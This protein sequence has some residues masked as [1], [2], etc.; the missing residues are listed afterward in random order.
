MPHEQMM[1]SPLLPAWL[2]VLWAVLLFAVVVVHTAHANLMSGQR[3]WWHIGHTAMAAVM[4]LM[5][6]LPPMSNPGPYRAGLL[7]FAAG[8]IALGVGTVV[9]ARREGGVCLLWVAS[10]VEMLAMTYMLLPMQ[11]RPGAV[12]Y[13]FAL[14]LAG[15]ALAWALGLWQREP[16]RRER[17]AVAA[18]AAQQGQGGAPAA[19]AEPEP[20]R[21]RLT[22]PGSRDV[23]VT[24]AVMSAS[25]AYMVVFM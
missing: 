13:V 6:L 9:L 16:A 14:Y 23:P 21:P 11:V 10:T 7:L 18:A 3:R 25:M 12:N 15:S 1:S 19:F 20:P 2:R 17:P 4:M 8:T 22:V 5:Y 24:L